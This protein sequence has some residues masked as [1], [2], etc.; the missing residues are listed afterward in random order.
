MTLTDERKGGKSP[1][2]LVRLK[3]TD[4]SAIMALENACFDQPW[5]RDNFLG[6]LRRRVTIPIGLRYDGILAAQ[7]FFWLIAPEIHLLNVAVAPHFR[8]RGL[9]RRLL[10]VMLSIGRKAGVDCVFL[11]ARAGNLA[12]IKLY[13]SL[14]FER[15]GTRPDYYEDGEDAL[16]MTLEI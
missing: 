2:T 12:A 4:L 7:C 10:S 1:Y 11:E 5:T 14:G 3:E 15:A 6:E 9:A 13:K 8:G 16:M